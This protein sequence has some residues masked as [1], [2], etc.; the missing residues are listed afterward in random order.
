MENRQAEGWDAAIGGHGMLITHIDFERSIWQINAVNNNTTH[1]RVTIV[2]ADGSASITPEGDAFP[3]TTGKSAFTDNTSPTSTLWN[4]S[5]LGRSVSSIHEADGLITFSFMQDKLATP[6]LLPPEDVTNTSFVARWT[7][8]DNASSY[9]LTVKALLPDSVRPVPVVDDFSLMTEG[10][11]MAKNNPAA[12]G[13]MDSL[14]QQP[15][16]SGEELY[17]ANG[18]VQIGRYGVS[19][20]LTTPTV[21]LAAADEGL[22]IV[23]A[24][25]AYANRSVNYDLVVTDA[26]TGLT[27]DS[28]R[29]KATAQLDT[30]IRRITTAS[31]QLRVTLRSNRERLFADQVRI[32]R[33]CLPNLHE[34]EV[35]PCVERLSHANSDV[36][37]YAFMF[38]IECRPGN[39]LIVH[40]NVN[41][42]RSTL[43]FWVKGT[44]YNNAIREIYD[45]LQ[46]AEINKRSSL[47]GGSID[48]GNAGIVR[49]KS[50]NHDDIW[51]RRK[52]IKEYTSGF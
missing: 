45:F 47:R 2:A 51:S 41:P 28:L 30:L 6:Q 36:T 50:I 37:E 7:P 32:V 1:P 40:E 21:V 12:T 33:G 26:E 46:S 9:T 17:A 35:I 44:E 11:Y 27:I 10:D 49:Y 42:D 22:T 34:G 43:L 24:W 19:G 48:V 8:I 39:I 5:P 15:G 38:S 3:G 13:R 25:R 52:A 16:W 14:T 18:Y 31:R 23:C 29:G 4:G 20:Q